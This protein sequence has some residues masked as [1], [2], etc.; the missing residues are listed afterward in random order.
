MIA[1]LS[2]VGASECL[3]ENAG[4][5]HHLV[6]TYAC[7]HQQKYSNELRL[8]VSTLEDD[9]FLENSKHFSRVGFN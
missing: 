9:I 4:K 7:L 2:V 6:Q 3:G 1:G 8:T 5:H